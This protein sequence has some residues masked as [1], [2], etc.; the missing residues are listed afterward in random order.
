VR[1]AILGDI[2]GNLQA[3][4]AVRDDMADRD[5]DQVLCVGDVVGYGAY[6][7]E[8]IKLLQ[9]LG[10]VCVAGNHDWGVIG[11]V[12]IRYFNADARDSIEWTRK[13]VTDTDR[14]FLSELELVQ[15]V[16]DITLVHSSL[17]APDCFDY[18]NTIY[19]VQ[20]HFSHLDTTICF[21]GHSHVPVMFLDTTPPDCFLSPELRVPDGRR[22]V[23]NVGSVGQP[24]NSDP[25]ASYCVYD[26]DER[27][28]WMRQVDYDVQGASQ[29]ILNAGLPTT[30][31]ARILLGR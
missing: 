21:V 1:Y 2:H 19:D 25:R 20:L 31:S 27:T 16:G 4:Q 30:N 29:D 5:V 9:D 15:V 7:S 26:S 3:F 23:I 28:A 17:F 24:R 10:G 8:C 22:A 11:K 6:P 12:D 14:D 13:H 18:I